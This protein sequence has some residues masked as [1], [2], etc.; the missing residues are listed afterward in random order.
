M[1]GSGS[2]GAAGWVQMNSLRPKR[3]LGLILWVLVTTSCAGQEG[4]ATNGREVAEK[5]SAEV[6]QFLSEQVPGGSFSD[7][8]QAMVSGEST[9]TIT[10]EEFSFEP[11][12]LIG[13]AGQ[14]LTVS[15]VNAGDGPHTFTVD[16]PRVHV[17]LR[18]AQ[19]G[20]TTVTI[21][22]SD[23]PILFYCRFHRDQ[24][25]VGALTHAPPT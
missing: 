20:Q 13:E 23:A 12:I 16:E 11:T 21:P 25:M 4:E 15:L 7:R 18:R 10:L 2:G 17:A 19:N 24:G 14:E 22:S 6:E 1:N 8:G 5:V 9:V 3:G